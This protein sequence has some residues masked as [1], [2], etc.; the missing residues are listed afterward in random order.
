MI[1]KFPNFEHSALAL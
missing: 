1:S